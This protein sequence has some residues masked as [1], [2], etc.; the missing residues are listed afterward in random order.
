[1]RNLLSLLFFCMVLFISCR[2]APVTDRL[3]AINETLGRTRALIEKNNSNARFNLDELVRMNFM[4]RDR[5]LP[6]RSRVAYVHNRVRAV[7]MYIDELRI[8][9]ADRPDVETMRKALYDTLET[10]SRSVIDTFAID[11]LLAEPWRKK[12][13]QQDV[14]LLRKKVIERLGLQTDTVP[15]KNKAMRMAMPGKLQ[16]DVAAVENILMDYCRLQMPHVCG[17]VRDDRFSAIALMSSE[18]VQAG[19]TIELIVGKAS[20]SEAYKPLVT[21]NGA[22]CEFGPDGVAVHQFTATGKPGRH[23]ALVCIS[24]VNA[25]GSDALFSKEL[26]Y[27]IAQ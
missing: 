26:E 7:N 20:F 10:F 15:W 11:T 9:M 2:Q 17:I 14:A 1:M 22:R 6:W 21:V 16:T 12:M 8:V 5:T 19:Q 24:H 4:L 27:I 3:Q 18:Q 13:I 25:D 23:T